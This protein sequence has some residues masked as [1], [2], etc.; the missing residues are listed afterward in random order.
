LIIAA[1]VASKQAIEL[2]KKEN[3]ADMVEAVTTPANFSSVSQFYK[4]FE[5]ITDDNKV[6]DILNKWQRRR[7][8]AEV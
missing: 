8:G 3:I 4:D 6:I 2:I 1:P 5:E 7:N